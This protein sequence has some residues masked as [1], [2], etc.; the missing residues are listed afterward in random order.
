[1]SLTSYR[2]APPRGQRGQN[3]EM[4]GGSKRGVEESIFAGGRGWI[5]P[6]GQ[7]FCDQAEAP[8]LGRVQTL[9]GHGSLAPGLRCGPSP[10][11]KR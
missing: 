4:P 6:S 2:A 8:D 9:R 7:W 10:V 1:M 11:G 3:R 5:R